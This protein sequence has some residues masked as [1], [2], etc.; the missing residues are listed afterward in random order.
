[1]I[2]T[3]Q[4]AE[5]KTLAHKLTP[6]VQIGKDGVTDNLV[7]QIDIVLENKELIKVKILANCDLEAKKLINELAEKLKANAV[8]AVGGVMV[9][10]RLSSK[11]G[12][13]HIL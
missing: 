1:M 9:L 7:A 3:R 13:K 8:L 11:D 10:Y 2:T 5:L 4:R 6:S 12:V